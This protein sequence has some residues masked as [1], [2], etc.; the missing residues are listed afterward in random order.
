[1]GR[2]VVSYTARNGND[3]IGTIAR[4][5]GLGQLDSSF[6]S[7]GIFEQPDSFSKDFAIFSSG[8]TNEILFST[9]GVKIHKLRS[10]GSLVG[11]FA[12]GGILEGLSTTLFEFDHN[13]KSHLDET[14]ARFVFSRLRGSFLATMQ[15][16]LP[17]GSLDESYGENGRAT[18]RFLN[19]RSVEIASITSDNNGRVYIYFN[20]KGKLRIFRLTSDGALDGS[21]ANE[22][23]FSTPGN[24]DGFGLVFK[25]LQ[26]IGN[27][28]YLFNQAERR[29]GTNS[30]MSDYGQAI[31]RLS[32]DGSLD[33][34]F[35]GG[36]G[37]VFR[38][39][40]TNKL[41]GSEFGFEDSGFFVDDQN[42]AI[43]TYVFRESNRYILVAERLRLNGSVDETFSKF[44]R[45]DSGLRNRSVNAIMSD[46]T[47]VLNAEGIIFA[48]SDNGQFRFKRTSFFSRFTPVIYSD[49]RIMIRTRL[50]FNRYLPNG[51]PD[52]TFGDNGFLSDE[53][54][55]GLRASFSLANGQSTGERSS[56]LNGTTNIRGRNLRVVKR[57][58][59]FATV[60][61]I[62]GNLVIFETFRFNNINEVHL[63]TYS[64]DDIVNAGSI[65]KDTIVNAGNGNNR[66]RTGSGNDRLFSLLGNSL[67]ISG[68]GDDHVIDSYGNNTVKTLG[69]N[70]TVEVGIG[71]DDIESGGGNDLVRAGA[72]ND[73]IKGGAG[74]DQLN[75]GL[76]NDRIDG[77]SGK[78][79]LSGGFNNDF[80]KG[81]NQSDILIGGPG[82]DVLS[83]LGGRD[84]VIGGDGADRLS[85]G[86]GDD[87]LISS[88]TI[89]DNDSDILIRIRNRWESSSGY[90]ARV[91][92][93]KSGF[94]F[95][96][97]Q[98]RINRSSVKTDNQ[99]DE[100][101]GNRDNDWFF[102]NS[103]LD[104]VFDRVSTEI[105][106]RV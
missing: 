40:L 37:K 41:R 23:A 62:N 36:D 9:S 27:K 65:S 81:G 54:V 33:R 82:N 99:R 67:L 58:G 64:G 13:Y 91:Q 10:N 53:Q 32:E 42:R 35:G 70:D 96:N 52:T 94:Q 59:E 55:T 72:G 31:I 71:N 57:I 19:P 26:V 83:G 102:V 3:R 4:I 104:R 77:G 30:R 39:T 79:I 5:N 75:G 98:I 89:H 28:I 80:L 78:N 21:F 17:D 6:S 87:I 47:V 20:L 44:I 69:G 92:V 86:I 15:K 93:I 66:I 100:I 16:F 25:N 2:L 60:Q 46:D 56:D 43:A 14:G 76:G 1:M 12:D 105:L 101:R 73:N 95:Q 63:V 103:S 22:G 90:S 51:N 29:F 48:L 24:V 34:T 85:G 18:L 61:K 7:D 106:D 50:G 88:R 8:N 49:G 45:E 11:S 74:N 68:A 84:I 97:K 38:A